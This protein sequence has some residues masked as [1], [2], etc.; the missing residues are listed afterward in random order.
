MIEA[1]PLSWPGGW[2]RSKKPKDSRFGTWNKKPSIYIGMVKVQ[3]EIRQLGGKNLIISSNLRLR[4]DGLPYSSQRM[5][6]DCGI[7][8]YFTWKDEPMVIASDNYNKPGCNLWA[9]GKTVESMRGIERWG[10]SELLNRAFTG[11]KQLPEKSGIVTNNWYDILKVSMNATKDEIIKAYKKKAK[12]YH[13][14]KETG[15][16]EMFLLVKDAY[17]QGLMNCKQEEI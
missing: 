8:I 11:F 6:E 3:N 2:K 13:P 9:I 16:E 7:A 14:D 15:D 1:Y 17:E 12:I 5:P 10:C 4:Q